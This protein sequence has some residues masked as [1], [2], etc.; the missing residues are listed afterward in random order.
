MLEAITNIKLCRAQVAYAAF[1]VQ[2]RMRIDNGK[3]IEE[4][5]LGGY[6]RGL[7][8]SNISFSTVIGNHVLQVDFLLVFNWKTPIALRNF[9]FSF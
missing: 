3:Y 4:N 2:P 9:Q 7:V 5:G 1:C 8:L 6:C